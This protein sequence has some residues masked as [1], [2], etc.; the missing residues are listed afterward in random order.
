MKYTVDKPPIRKGFSFATKTSVVL[1]ALE[2]IRDDLHIQINYRSTPGSVLMRAEYWFPNNRVDYER[3]YLIIGNVLSNSRKTTM[4]VMERIIGPEFRTQL[5]GISLLSDSS[6]YLNHGE[7]F[8][9]SLTEEG[10]MINGT[11]IL[12]H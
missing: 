1:N 4:E 8:K 9:A 7:F 5:R 6:T 12:P 10:Y 3:I 11:L 2:G